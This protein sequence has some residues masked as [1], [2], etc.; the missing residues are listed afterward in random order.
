MEN[1]NSSI[2]TLLERLIELHQKRDELLAVLLERVTEMATLTKPLAAYELLTG[3]KIYKQEVL[4]LLKISPRTYDRHKANG[5]L[6]PHGLGHDF[7]Y[8]EDLVEA[9]EE[10]KRKGRL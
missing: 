10:G 7:Y 6:K 5:L 9:I 3:I 4:E 8:P 1:I 2:L